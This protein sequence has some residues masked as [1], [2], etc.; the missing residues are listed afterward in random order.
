MGVATKG[1]DV[2]IGV[3]WHDSTRWYGR[4]MR[5]GETRGNGTRRRPAMT[6]RSREVL[7]AQLW[8]WRGVQ[9]GF[10]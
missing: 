10:E 3:L 4:E 1:T 7:L 9:E 2:I 6:P 5:D 8:Q